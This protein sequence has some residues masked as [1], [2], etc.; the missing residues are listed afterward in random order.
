[1]IV[2]G[3][4]APQPRP[5]TVLVVGARGI[6]NVEGGAEKNAEELFP[7]LA[8]RGYRVVLMGLDGLIGNGEFRG[9]QLRAAP[10]SR[11][12]GTDKLAYYLRA[13]QTAAR[14]R[15]DIVHLQGLGAALFLCAYK[16]LGLR[17]VVRYGSADYLVGKWGA[18]GKAGFLLSEFQLRF[19]DAV[20]AVSPSLRARLQRRGVRRRI[21]LI[22]NAVDPAP[23]QAAHDGGFILTVGRVTAQKNVANLLRAHALLGEAAPELRIAGGLDDAAYVRELAPLLNPRA[24]LLGRIPRYALAPLYA[25]CRLFV[26]ASMHEGCSNAVLEAVSHKCPLLLSDIPENR[27]LGLPER[28]YFDA[29]DPAAMAAAIRRALAHPAD[30]VADPARFAS[31]STVAEDTHNVYQLVLHARS[32]AAGLELDGARRRA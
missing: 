14:L 16:A 12:F 32:R 18:I 24:T 7:R 11:L 9:V 20:I 3:G 6:P 28:V 29:A 2:T 22:A 10:R 15:P 1:M 17:T 25:G 23:A 26:N 5:P 13:L 31:W 27:D 8:E 19:A 21:A 4:A 30:Y